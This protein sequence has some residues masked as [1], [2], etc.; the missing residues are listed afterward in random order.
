MAN[1]RQLK[2]KWA[3]DCKRLARMWDA[4]IA[5]ASAGELDMKKLRLEARARLRQMKARPIAD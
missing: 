3:A 4:G 5:S 1:K 2:L